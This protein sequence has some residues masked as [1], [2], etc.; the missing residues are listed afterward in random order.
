MG[1]DNGGCDSSDFTDE[2]HIAY[3]WIVAIGYRL[4]GTGPPIAM[5]HTWPGTTSPK[6]SREAIVMVIIVVVVVV[7]VIG[8]QRQPSGVSGFL[9]SIILPDHPGFERRR[10]V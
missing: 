5:L 3:T 8:V 1:K 9:E 6:G 4:F 10:S 7:A 2:A